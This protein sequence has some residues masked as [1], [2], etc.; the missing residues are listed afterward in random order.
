MLKRVKIPQWAKFS[1]GF[2]NA[3]KEKKPN[4]R[5][6]NPGKRAKKY[7]QSGTSQRTGIC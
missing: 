7:T 1:I 3:K 6:Q 2:V 4:R 5:F